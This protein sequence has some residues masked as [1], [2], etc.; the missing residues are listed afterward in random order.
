[1]AG[2][3][4]LVFLLVAIALLAGAGVRFNVPYPIVLVVGG[5]LLGLVPGLPSPDLDPDI[6]FFAFLPP[7]LYA[8]AFQASAYE[9]RANIVPISRLAVGLVLVT[10][11]AVAAVAHWV[12]DL[13][14]AA[15]FVLG[16]VLGP[17]DPVAAAAIVRRLGAPARIETILEGEALVNDG[18]A[19][20]AYKIALA[21]VGAAALGPFETVG[22]FVLVAAGG[23]AIGL[24]VGWV[25]AH[26]RIAAREPSI[27]VVLSVLTP[28]AAYV[29]AEKLHV[30]GV[31]AVVAAGVYVGT[32]SLE[33]SEAG[34]RLRTVAFW[35][36]S[37]F[38]LNSLLF[39]LVGLQVTRIVG[40]I[41]G[42]ELGELAAQAALLAAVVM[43]VRL[44]WNW[45]VPEVTHIGFLPHD[46]TSVRERLVIGWSGM[47][48][49]VSLAA[50][51]AIPVA[52][53]PDRDL[54][55]F[56]AYG[57]VLITLVLPGLTLAPL[58][59]ALGLGQSAERRRQEVEARLRLTHAALE[60]LEDMAEHGETNGVVDH[61]RKRYEMRL[62]RLQ[63]RLDV[64]GGHPDHG[65]DAART[66]VDV[67]EHERGVL[68]EMRRE[69]AFPAELLRSLEAE[70]DVDEARVRSRGR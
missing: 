33:L 64:A 58:I 25:F 30:S 22:K 57:V 54:V 50:A 41:E 69:R 8:A 70:I 29:P 34:G 1:M 15:A 47:R 14:W 9:L 35:Q 66:Q 6:V 21:A 3:E 23:I 10:V 38:L 24:A 11:V 36:A 53:F 55:I 12:A 28:F 51:L 56:L 49:A 62:D 27:D 52:G 5:L 68:R 40:D 46:H 65:T 42:A 4:A 37:E 31:L 63:D 19:L 59:D 39:L 44:L 20:T 2:A 43:G 18:T 48:G 17:T 26:L 13:P 67:L 32:R 16:A 45:L 60:R 61:L 7:L